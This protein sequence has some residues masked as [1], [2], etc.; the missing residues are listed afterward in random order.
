LALSKFLQPAHLQTPQKDW[1][2]S[3]CS[4]YKHHV[5]FICIVSVM[6]VA[7]LWAAARK[8]AAEFV[9]P[10]Y[11][12]LHFT[13]ITVLCFLASIIL[14][15]LEHYAEHDVAYVDCLFMAVSAVTLTGL[16]TVDYVKLS[17]GG[18][19][20]VYI[21]CMLGS[22][23]F[24]S[25][26]PALIRLHFL[27]RAAMTTKSHGRSLVRMDSFARA[28]L[29]R[30]VEGSALRWIV[31]IAVVY[32]ICTQVISS[33]ILGCYFALT[34]TYK[35]LFASHGLSSWWF[36][37]LLSGASF[38]N[39]GFTLF[40]DSLTSFARDYL[41]LIVSAVLIVAGNTGYP[42]AVRAIVAVIHKFRP[43]DP[44]IELLLKHPRRFSTHIFDAKSTRLLAAML[45]TF[46]VVQM[47]LYLAIDFHQSYW[48]EDAV[49]QRVLMCF[50]QSIST[51][52]GGFNVIDLSRTSPAVQVLT[53]LLMYVA[54]YPFIT[55]VQRSAEHAVK[56]PKPEAAAHDLDTSALQRF[57]ES[58][59]E[60]LEHKSHSHEEEEV[61]VVDHDTVDGSS[62]TQSTMNNTLNNMSHITPKVKR[63][64]RTYSSYFA[65]PLAVNPVVEQKPEAGEAI[66][67]LKVYVPGRLRSVFSRDMF[68]IFGALI[69]I[70]AGVNHQ[71][72]YDEYAHHFNVFG[73]IFEVVS[74][75]GTVGLSLGHPTITTSFSTLYS[76]FGKLVVCLLM[77]LGRHRGMPSVVDSAVY[78]P[79]LLNAIPSRS[80]S[81]VEAEA[82]HEGDIQVVEMAPKSVKPF[83]RVSGIA[84]MPVFAADEH[85]LPP[86]QQPT[87]DAS[88]PPIIATDAPPQQ[89]TSDTTSSMPPIMAIGMEAGADTNPS[90][91]DTVHVHMD[92][93]NVALETVS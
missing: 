59:L 74:A 40:L 46:A 9:R 8:H 27:S 87:N 14:Y 35:D 67:P 4:L 19:T 50:Y 5:F 42:I 63:R 55:A 30:A 51:R 34:D 61:S 31:A 88:M 33:V 38:N 70:C 86:H 92:T 24:S 56:E 47:V 83:R 37:I 6:Q 84:P 29:I 91:S 48:A 57:I 69:L 16:T 32:Y 68:L 78:M 53:V 85:T 10:T 17:T 23:V 18:Q 62:I 20:C 80:A 21:F 65:T 66:N 58:N 75:Y 41:V 54:A 2:T 45:T 1:L 39:S 13:Y 79:T 44:A 26:A 15:L 72:Q 49:H 28:T 22:N 11:F 43:N 73:V 71:L 60:D 3:L 93:A 77:L 90:K 76:T 81:V 89:P 25:I 7:W 36:A 64:M 82:A 52:A 12:K